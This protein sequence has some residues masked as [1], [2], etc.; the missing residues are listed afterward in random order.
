MSKPETPCLPECRIASGMNPAIAL[1]HV[2]ACPNA[3][4]AEAPPALKTGYWLLFSG[5]EWQSVTKA[6]FIA[7]ERAYGFHSKFGPN[8][9]A[10]SSFC[11]DGIEGRTFWTSDMAPAPPAPKR[12]SMAQARETLMGQLAR[13]DAP[14][15]VSEPPKAD[16][17]F[18]QALQDVLKA[19][20]A[21]ICDLPDDVKWQVQ[22]IGGRYT[23]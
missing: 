13:T 18:F 5:M 14:A 12:V 23:Q 7:A 16:K 22:K 9:V 15:P 10:T 2:P 1:Y 6:A 19:H 21:R 4:K 20:I 17:P 3:P 11:G 8:E